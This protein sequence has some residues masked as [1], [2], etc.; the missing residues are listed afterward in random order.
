MDDVV[1]EVVLAERDEDLLPEELVGAVALRHGARAHRG[2]IG[3]RLRLGQVHRARPCA[4]RPST[5]GTSPCCSGVPH[6]LDCFDRALRQQRTQV[7][8][9][10]RRMPHLLDWR[11]DEL[12]QALAAVLHRLRESVPPV[13]R[14][15][16]VGGLEPGRRLDRAVGQQLRS[17]AI[18]CRIE[19]VEH[20]GRKPG[21]LFEDRRHRVGRR[22]LEPGQRGHLAQSGKVVQHELHFGQRGVIGAHG[23]VAGWIEPD[24][25][26]DRADARSQCLAPVGIA[27][28]ARWRR[29]LPSTKAFLRC[30]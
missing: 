16:P 12:R 30:R 24:R 9:H 5:A 7:E 10:V 26:T 20:F 19:R 11:R 29:Y 8:R 25:L 2:E 23:Q 15:L 22:V 3:A 21:G 14:E 6:K 17:L 13:L 1:G 18:A 4:G 28:G 27:A